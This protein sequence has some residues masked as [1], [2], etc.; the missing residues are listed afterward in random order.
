MQKLAAMGVAWKE[1]TSRVRES[2]FS[3]FLGDEARLE[4]MICSQ[5]GVVFKDEYHVMVPGQVTPP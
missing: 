4:T 5:T 1:L 2:A 3:T